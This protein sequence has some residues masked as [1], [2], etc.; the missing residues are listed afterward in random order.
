M[1]CL[2]LASVP[3]NLTFEKLDFFQILHYI[4]IHSGNDSSLDGIYYKTRIEY[5][6]S[7]ESPN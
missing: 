3:I 4:F 6:I 2:K 7:T 5:F 1:K